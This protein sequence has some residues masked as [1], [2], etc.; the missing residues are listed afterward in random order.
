MILAKPQ[1]AVQVPGA[2]AQATASTRQSSYYWEYDVG[3]WV[4]ANA[5]VTSTTRAAS[6]PA[7]IKSAQV[8]ISSAAVPTVATTQPGAAIGTNF[9]WGG[10]EGRVDLKFGPFAPGTDAADVDVTIRNNSTGEVEAITGGSIDGDGYYLK[11]DARALPYVDENFVSGGQSPSFTAEALK[12]SVYQGDVYALTGTLYEPPL[13]TDYQ[14]PIELTQAPYIKS[15][16][17]YAEQVNIGTQIRRLPSGEKKLFSLMDGDE[18]VVRA[19]VSLGRGRGGNWDYDFGGGAAFYIS[20]PTMR[21]ANG[22]VARIKQTSANP[23]ARVI[24]YKANKNSGA[25]SDQ[26]GI[27][28]RRWGDDIEIRWREFDDDEIVVVSAN[29]YGNEPTKQFYAVFPDFGPVGPKYFHINDRLRV[30]RDSKDNQRIY[31]RKNII[32]ADFLVS[33]V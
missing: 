5:S 16:R 28:P 33:G 24:I 17:Q 29:H 20:P 8:E 31:I 19:G 7:Y 27:Y 6:N 4:L 21:P 11:T 26:S 25:I 2:I 3:E 1:S 23:Q 12:R 15:W 32:T 13:V 18:W 22:G 10:G 30:L 14:N 9:S